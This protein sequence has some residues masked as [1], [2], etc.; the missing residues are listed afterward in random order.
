MI[1]GYDK[2]CVKIMFLVMDYFTISF[3]KD[4]IDELSIY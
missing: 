3:N 1:I 4:F 2:D